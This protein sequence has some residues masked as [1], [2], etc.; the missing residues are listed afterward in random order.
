M[1]MSVEFDKQQLAE[2]Q[3]FAKRFPETAD[4]LARSAINKALKLAERLVVR[5]LSVNMGIEE[6][7]F[8]T[9]HAW[10]VRQSG[11]R[12]TRAVQRKNATG[13]KPFGLLQISGQRIPLVWFRAQATPLRIRP[14]SE[15][16][17]VRLG[18]HDY[19]GNKTSQWYTLYKWGSGV[20]YQLGREGRKLLKEGFMGRG[21]RGTAESAFDAISG[22]VGVFVRA[23]QG[24]KQ[25]PRSKIVEP[26]G[27]SVPEAAMKD[28][29]IRSDLNEVHGAMMQDLST[30]IDR[31]LKRKAREAA[32][33]DSDLD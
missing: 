29:R 14:K 1:E 28:S 31:A 24:D 16:V 21:R 32:R 6:K 8:T 25:V 2:L 3:G 27:P 19:T 33:A 4:K 13:K 22:H 18:G 23:K 9:P 7:E 5:T 20:T 11:K 30:R 10:G 15:W 26:K 17:R 12:T